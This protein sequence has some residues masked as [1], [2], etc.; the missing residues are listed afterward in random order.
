VIAPQ[1][2][3]TANP[4]EQVRR[5]ALDLRDGLLDVERIAGDVTGVRHLLLGEGL[6]V[7]GGMV[8]GAQVSGGL[9]DGLGPEACPGAIAG[10]GV[11]GDAHYGYVAAGNVAQLGQTRK[12]GRSRVTGNGGAADRLDRPVIVVLHGSS[13]DLDL[14]TTG[15]FP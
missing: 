10:A 7:V 6:G 14:F 15:P 5:C 11:E 13:P 1:A 2:N 8:L 4:A 12:G 9:A 3:D